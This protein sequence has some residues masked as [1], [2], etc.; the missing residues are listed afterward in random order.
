MTV[1]ALIEA[2]SGVDRDLLVWVEG[3][4]CVNEATAVVPGPFALLIRSGGREYY[5]NGEAM[6]DVERAM[7]DI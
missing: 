3:C 7:R 5:S 6:D 4:D 1:R 2:L